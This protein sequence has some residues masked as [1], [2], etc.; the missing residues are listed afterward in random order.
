MFLILAVKE[1]MGAGFVDD[2]VAERC[3]KGEP[4]KP[5]ATEFVITYTIHLY[6]HDEISIRLSTA[7]AFNGIER[8][9]SLSV[10]TPPL[11][12]FKKILSELVSSVN[13][14]YPALTSP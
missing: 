12:S 7:M 10:R 9:S 1:M 11:T 3:M 13:L 4:K 2:K 6:I 8:I 14:L 5:T